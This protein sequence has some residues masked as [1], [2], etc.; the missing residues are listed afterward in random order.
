MSSQARRRLRLPVEVQNR[1]RD[2]GGFLVFQG[3]Q[4]GAAGGSLDQERV[5]EGSSSLERSWE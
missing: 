2:G 3:A 4:A 5:P 1:G